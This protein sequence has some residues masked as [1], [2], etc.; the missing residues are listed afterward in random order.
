MI[1]EN[2][3]NIK[4]KICLLGDNA[5]GKT[6]LIRK[7]VLDIF[8]EK[9]ISTFGTN[10]TKKAV[11][12]RRPKDNTF[13]NIALIIWDISGDM[14]GLEKNIKSFNSFSAQKK[15]FENAQGGIVV[16][17]I[18]RPNTFQNITDWVRSF[19]EIAGDM[20]MIFLGNKIDLQPIAKV[21]T[22]ELE[23][24][25]NKN[26]SKFLFTSAKSGQNVDL[27]FSKMAKLLATPYLEKYK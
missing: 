9:Y 12:F 24:V 3:I 2:E 16:C 21:S 22:K 17:D 27:A 1:K 4:G 19:K 6:S 5:V 14:S 13:I 11:R 10:V 8:E 18:T 20:P 25:A 23:N 15:Y 26:N 7:Y